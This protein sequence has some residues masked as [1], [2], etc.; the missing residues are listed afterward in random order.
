MKILRWLD[1]NFEAIIMSSTLLLMSGIIAVQVFFRYVLL[2]SLAWSEEVSRYL[3]IYMIYFGISYGVRKSRHIKIDFII[4]L[5][6]DRGKKILALVSDFL[7]LTFAVVITSQAGIV[8]ETI[9]R[10]GQITGATQMPMAVVYSAVPLGYGLVCLRLIQNI[11]YKL[12]NFA[13]PYEVFAF[14]G[15]SVIPV[16]ETTRLVETDDGCLDEELNPESTDAATAVA[17]KGETR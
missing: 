11:I 13:K 10:L 6:S 17:A 12:K 2:N 5:A 7:F 15:E 3:F 4:S 16:I 1:D 9:A 14:R 8:A